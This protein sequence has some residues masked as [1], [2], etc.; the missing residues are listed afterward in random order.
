MEGS[1]PPN[2][3]IVLLGATWQ[4]TS[5]SRQTPA[6]RKPI[7]AAPRGRS[8]S[9]MAVIGRAAGAAPALLCRFSRGFR[10]G[11]LTGIPPGGYCVTGWPMVVVAVAP[12]VAAVGTGRP[13]GD[14]AV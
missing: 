1:I 4:A 8:C 14:D 6:G 3:S 2:G 5:D 9:P 12:T 10:R 7:D 13:N 11:L